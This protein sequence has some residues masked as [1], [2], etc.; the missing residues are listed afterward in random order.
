MI[1]DTSAVIAILFAER[2]AKTYAQVIADAESCRMS[3]ATLVEA[4]IVIDV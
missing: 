4:S 1:V 3:A 2:D